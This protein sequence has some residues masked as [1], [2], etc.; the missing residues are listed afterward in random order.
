MTVSVTDICNLALAR[1]GQSEITNITDDNRRAKLCNLHY[2]QKRDTLLRMYRWKFATKRASLP[3]LTDAPTFG[4]TYAYQ[5]P[6]DC[7]RVISVNELDPEYDPD[8]D[9][10]LWDKEGSTIVTDLAAPLDIKYIS[11]VTDTTQFDACFVDTLAS[12][13][14]IYLAPSLRE[15]ETDLVS[16]FRSEFNV[17]VKDAKF[18]NAIEARPRYRRNTSSAWARGYHETY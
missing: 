14:A 17:L 8:L 5:E 2:E 7:I 6:T 9:P 3:A 12:F 13:I 15:T 10:G 16:T 4:Y 11:R 18:V 1:V